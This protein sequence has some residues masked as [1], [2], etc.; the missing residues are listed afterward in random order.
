[1]ARNAQD[2]DGRL[3]AEWK[4]GQQPNGKHGID[5]GVKTQIVGSRMSDVKPGRV[6]LAAID[7]QGLGRGDADGCM[8]ANDCPCGFSLNGKQG[9][10]EAERHPKC[11]YTYF[12]GYI[13]SHFL[14]LSLM[15]QNPSP[16]T[17]LPVLSGYRK[18]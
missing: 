2:G 10:E 17:P 1:M 14:I 13:R 3:Q 15:T 6:K 12:L 4:D 11:D 7:G 5:S 16:T 9:G 18:V 8:I